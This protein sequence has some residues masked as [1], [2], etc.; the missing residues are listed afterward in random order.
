MN[1]SKRTSSVIA[2][3]IVVVLILASALVYTLGT[4]DSTIAGLR[5]QIAT[6]QETISDLRS[7]ISNLIS[8]NGQLESQ[9]TSL[10]ATVLSLNGQVAI[11][12]AQISKLQL[13]IQSDQST[14]DSLQSQLSSASAQVSSLQSQVQSLQQRPIVTTTRVLT[15]TVT[16]DYYVGGN[17]VGMTFSMWSSCNG[18]TRWCNMTTAGFSEPVPDTFDYNDAWSSTIPIT[19]YYLTL[20]QF[21]Q[22]VNCYSLSRISCVQGTYPIIGPTT[23]SDDTFRLA[24][25]CGGYIAVYLAT[26]SGILYPNV[27]VTYNPASAPTGTCAQP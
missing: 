26:E 12:L 10:N 17:P 4:S 15:V 27:S 3:A 13:Q 22:F 19:V 20:S 14:I 2:S 7:Q 5:S 23:S 21:A 11:D 24:E 16:Q 8:Q 18:I 6:D 25:G 1:T 9:A